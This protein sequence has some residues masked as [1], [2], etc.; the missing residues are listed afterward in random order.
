MKL[1]REQNKRIQRELQEKFEEFLRRV[2]AAVEH[3]QRGQR[4][5]VSAKNNDRRWTNR[6]RTDLVFSRGEGKEDREEEMEALSE[7]QEEEGGGEFHLVL[8]LLTERIR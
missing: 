6:W 1:D 5:S 2:E 3:S 7:V 8:L 4:N